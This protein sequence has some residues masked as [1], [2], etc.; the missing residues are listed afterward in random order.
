VCNYLDGGW[1]LEG[2]T[3]MGTW[4]VCGLTLTWGG[5]GVWTDLDGSMQIGLFV[6]ENKETDDGH[7]HE[8]G[9]HEACVVDEDVDVF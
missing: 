3:L 7:G 1:C 4:S 6:S 8:Y 9:L 5:V 2:I